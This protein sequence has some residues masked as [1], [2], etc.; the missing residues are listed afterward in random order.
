[1]PSVART[2]GGSGEDGH[3]GVLRVYNVTLKRCIRY[4]YAMAEAQILG[5]PKWIG[6]F[7]YDIVA[8]ADHPAGEPE[9]CWRI[10]LSWSFTTNLTRF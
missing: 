6:D 2:A 9:P 1:M 10:A 7:R 5:G 3:D 4:A 8:K